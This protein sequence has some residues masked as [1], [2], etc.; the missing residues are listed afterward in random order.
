LEYSLNLTESANTSN[1][2]K[3]AEKQRQI[4]KEMQRYISLPKAVIKDTLRSLGVILRNFTGVVTV[5]F[6]ISVFFAALRVAVYRKKFAP[7]V[8]YAGLILYFIVFTA[9]FTYLNRLPERV[10]I[11]LLY[12]MSAGFFSVYVNTLPDIGLSLFDGKNVRKTGVFLTL[13]GAVVILISLQL[14]SCLSSVQFVFDLSCHRIKSIFLTSVMPLSGNLLSNKWMRD[15]ASV[16][17]R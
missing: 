1:F 15:C 4:N 14:R 5:V 13:A 10:Y 17:D 2:E 3:M 7:I 16:V 8:I 12:A 9:Y 11:P 6:A